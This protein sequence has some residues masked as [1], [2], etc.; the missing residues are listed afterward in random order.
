MRTKSISNT[1]EWDCDL[2]TGIARLSP[3]GA[4]YFEID[5]NELQSLLK[6][7]DTMIG[8]DGLPHDKLPHPRL[9][10]TFPRVVGYYARELGLMSMEQAIHQMTG[11][12]ASVF[13]LKD[14]GLIKPGHAADLV[15]FDPDRILDV[16]DFD[17]PIQPASGISRVY[18]NGR[19]VWENGGPTGNRPGM[20][21]TRAAA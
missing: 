5:E 10:G 3:A 11:L 16:A 6:L 15:L 2:E 13:G 7:P 20:W 4:C 19:V 1:E 17:D 8:S 21:L 18:V 9:W 12:T 14:R